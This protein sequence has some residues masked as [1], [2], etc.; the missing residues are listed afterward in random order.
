MVQCIIF[1]LTEYQTYHL[2]ERAK[3][4]LK[5]KALILLGTWMFLVH[6]MAMHKAILFTSGTESLMV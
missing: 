6:V 4:S 1:I 3:Q 2:H 5:L